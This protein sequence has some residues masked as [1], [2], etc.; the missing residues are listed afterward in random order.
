[1]EQKKNLRTKVPSGRVKLEGR[2]WYNVKVSLRPVV[3]RLRQAT[4]E[5]LHQLVER[6]EG[7]DAYPTLSDCI[8]DA[9]E[10]WL[11]QEPQRNALL[12]PAGARRRVKERL[13]KAEPSHPN[14][15]PKTLDEILGEES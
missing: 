10:E 11:S 12:A 3:V 6:D 5:A 2:R 1:M 8:R 13:E 15:D 7:G 4:I 9:L 14:P